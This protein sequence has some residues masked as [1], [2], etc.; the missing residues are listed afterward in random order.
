MSREERGEVMWFEIRLMNPGTVHEQPVTDW[1]F[2][3]KTGQHSVNCGLSG[4]LGQIA[5]SYIEEPSKFK[6]G[7]LADRMQ[8]APAEF[9]V[10]P[11]FATAIPSLV[12]ALAGQEAVT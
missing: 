11:M 5:R 9:S 2:T 8:D 6:R 7:L 1:M 12:K 4:E 3:N 10:Y